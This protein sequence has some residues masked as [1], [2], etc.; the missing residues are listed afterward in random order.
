MEKR[1]NTVLSPKISACTHKIA[2]KYLWQALS[3]A[4]VFSLKAGEK[5]EEAA[6]A[7]IK[8]KK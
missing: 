2:G 3:G 5:E 6:A 7:E 1:N 8:T 4:A